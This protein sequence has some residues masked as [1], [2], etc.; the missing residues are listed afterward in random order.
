MPFD[1]YIAGFYSGSDSD[2]DEDEAPPKASAPMNTD[3]FKVDAAS[4]CRALPHCIPASLGFN[5]IDGRDKE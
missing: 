4:F 1:D 2:D 3:V 5:E